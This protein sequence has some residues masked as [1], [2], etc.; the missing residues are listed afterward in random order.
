MSALVER[1]DTYRLLDAAQLVKHA[2]GLARRF[3]H[4]PAVLLY[5]FWE[6]ADAEAYA[7]FGLSRSAA[8]FLHRQYRSTTDGRFA[9]SG[10]GAAVRR[11][12]LEVG[13]VLVVTR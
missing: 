8:V 9:R 6:P 2:F 1:P 12:G 11:L 7:T 5:L 3:P 13:G 10:R 4:E